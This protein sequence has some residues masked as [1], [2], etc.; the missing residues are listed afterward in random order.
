M[1]AT[2]IAPS[3][4]VEAALDPLQQGSG[5]VEHEKAVPRYQDMLEKQHGVLFVVQPAQRVT[6]ASC[7][8]GHR[9]PAQ[10]FQPWS[11]GGYGEGKH[12]S[13]VGSAGESVGQRDVGFVGEWS[14]SSQLFGSVN[15]HAFSGLLHHV[16]R[17]LFLL[18]FPLLVLGLLTAVH[19]GV[20][21][22]MGQEQVIFHAV[23]VVVD[24]VFS[25]IAVGVL[26]GAKGV[27]HVVQGDDKWCQNIRTAPQLAPR[28]A[29]PNLAIP[30]LPS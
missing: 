17:D 18:R 20:A 22:R 14:G 29:V 12:E 4:K 2:E 1:N 15:H 8:L 16:Q 28:L 27:L 30:A 23:A 11:I 10:N 19:L 21:Q 6:V 25:E 7:P 13:G 24:H 5:V 9:L 3:L 26:D